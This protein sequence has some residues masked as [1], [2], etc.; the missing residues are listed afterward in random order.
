MKNPVLKIQDFCFMRQGKILQDLTSEEANLLQSVTIKTDANENALLMLHGFGSSPAVYRY[1]L[2]HLSTSYDALFCPLL[3]GHGYN[4]ENFRNV[5]ATDW[6]SYVEHIYDELS[7]QYKNIDVLGLSLGGLLACHLAQTKNVR[8]VYLLAPALALKTIPV[9]T[10]PL[11][12]ALIYLQIKQIPN[13][14]GNILNKTHGELTFR[15]LPMTS[16]REIFQLVRTFKLQPFTARTT[17]FLGG[18]DSV[19]DNHKV[20]NLIKTLPHGDIHW[21]ENSAHVLPLDND[22]HTMIDKIQHTLTF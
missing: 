8:H 1:M 3:P 6:L 16:I 20:L 7:V 12:Q 5:R 19:I 2:P 15:Q 17:I 10:Y 11:I 13:R 9:I 14:G 21:L 4:I 18:E 22:V